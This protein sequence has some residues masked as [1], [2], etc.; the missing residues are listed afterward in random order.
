MI[1]NAVYETNLKEIPLV[2]RGK[3]R[4]I[5][6]LG[7]SLL[8][9]ATDRISAF[10][11]V[12]PD[13]IPDKGRIL[14]ALS[15]FWFQFLSNVCPNHFLSANPDD[16]PP[17]CEPYREVLI[18]RS[19]MVKKA[20]IFPIECIVRGYL[21]GSGWKDY[22][23]TG[24][25]CGIQL[26]SGLRFAE[27]LPEPIFTPSTKAEKG[28]HDEN[29]S[30]EQMKAIVGMENAERLRDLSIKL[31]K[32]AADYAERCGI[33]LADTKFEFGLVNGEIT[34]V[35]EV[36]TPDSSRFW[37]GDSYKVGENPESFDKQY[38]RDFLMESGWKPGHLPPH[39]P[40][41]VIENTR[42]RYLE[43]LKRLTG[44]EKLPND[45]IIQFPKQP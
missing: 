15:L 30:F 20:E 44:L 24:K 40:S 4:D 5:Y 11:V 16:Y 38:I 43:A 28:A 35:D 2:A 1:E 9:V 21:V 27:K 37:P 29:I 12:L 7:K 19:M 34:L 41:D 6:D 36:L 45:Q 26:P 13:P 42:K 23:K 10:D 14:T 33:L 22:Q 17:E 8:I 3:V 18:G 32:K 39:L 25:V 31:Y